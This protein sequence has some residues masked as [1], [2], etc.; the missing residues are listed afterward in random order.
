MVYSTGR[1]Y[2]DI[3]E[4]NQ[5]FPFDWYSIK[6]YWLRKSILE[7]GLEISHVVWTKMAKKDVDAVRQK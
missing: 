1:K 4:L 7:L 3:N 5:F 2:E 6:K